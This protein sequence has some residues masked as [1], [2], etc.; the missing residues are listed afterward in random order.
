MRPD[1]GWGEPNFTGESHRAAE[2]NVLMLSFVKKKK[3]KSIFKNPN[4]FVEGKN[5]S[6]KGEQNLLHPSNSPFL[7]SCVLPDLWQKHLWKPS[8]PIFIPPC[9][10]NELYKSCT[11][12]CRL[13]LFSPVAFDREVP[14]PQLAIVV[15]LGKR[16]Q[17]GH[18]VVQSWRGRTR[19]PVW[20]TLF[21][22]PYSR[23]KGRVGQKYYLKAVKPKLFPEAGLW[24]TSPFPQ[25]VSVGSRE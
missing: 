10:W 20:N 18:G 13:K 19:S 4:I 7:C 23:R 2:S 16:Q 12:K 9:L 21:T 6:L 5:F 1:G 14:A 8:K 25:E 3:K 24:S 11:G 15:L 17:V 22:C